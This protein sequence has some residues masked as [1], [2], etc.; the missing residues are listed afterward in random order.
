MN[1]KNKKWL[2]EKIKLLL[3]NKVNVNKMNK[4]NKKIINWKK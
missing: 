4:K 2:I 1:K 3:A